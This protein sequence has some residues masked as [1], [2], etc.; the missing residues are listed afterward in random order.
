VGKS[1]E[2]R[3]NKKRVPRNSKTNVNQRTDF[4]ITMKFLVGVW[5]KVDWTISLPLKESPLPIKTKKTVE[6]V[7]MPSPPI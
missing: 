4:R 5:R 1:L 2:N 6:K 7:I 3:M